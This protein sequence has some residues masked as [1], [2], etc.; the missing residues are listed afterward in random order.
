MELKTILQGIAYTSSDK[1]DHIDIQGLSADSK[2]IRP[3]FIFVAVRGHKLNGDQFITEAVSRGAKVI[4]SQDDFS[5]SGDVKKILV[6]DTRIILPKLAG[7]FFEN[8]GQKLKIIGV[9]GTNGKTTI[10]YLLDDI[11]TKAGFKVGL[12]GTIQYRLN[13]RIIP[14]S[15]TTPG[16]IEIQGFLKEMADHNL[17]YAVIE[18]SSHA[19]DQH[20]VDQ[21]NFETAIFTNLTLDHLDYH[22]NFENYFLAKA[23]LFDKLKPGA[24]A[25]INI[26]D[27]YGLKLKNKIKKNILS[28]ALNQKADIYAQDIKLTLEGSEFLV[29]T[30][31]GSFGLKSKLIGLHNVYNILAAVGAAVA[32]NIRLEVIREFLSLSQGAPGR[33]EAVEEGQPFKVF[34]DYAHTD[35]A[36][37]NVLTILS[38]V[39]KQKILLLFGCGGDRDKTKRP[40]MA[41]AASQ[42]ADWIVVTSDNPRREEPQ[43]I[44]NE[45]ESGLPRG[46]KNYSKILDR[47][48]AIEKIISLAQKNDIIL[49]AGKGHENYQIFKDTIA[50]FNDKEIARKYLRARQDNLAKAAF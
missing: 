15:N 37:K 30:P 8:P 13:Q 42:F 26:D 25:I 23:K 16:P 27:P 11:L 43:Q 46:F 1:L 33:L 49:I 41:K 7:N 32:L 24:K 14:A 4:I 22:K 48:E 28:Y 12:I 6:K 31:A 18:V 40:L 50:P 20:R 38:Q 21:I 39:K 47:E 35:D 36:L 44:I 9:T 10:T 45:I 5:V 19:L 34:I 3:D 29:I 17:D 2:N